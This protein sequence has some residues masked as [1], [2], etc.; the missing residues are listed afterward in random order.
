MESGIY[1][2]EVNSAVLQTGPA[3]AWISTSLSSVRQGELRI[4]EVLVARLETIVSH[5]WRQSCRGA[6]YAEML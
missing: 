5:R 3:S 2:N 1:R 6:K 4:A